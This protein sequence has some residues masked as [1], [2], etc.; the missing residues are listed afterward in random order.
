MT[1]RDARSKCNGEQWEK[2]GSE[3][4]ICVRSYCCYSMAAMMKRMMQPNQMLMRSIPTE[5]NG[6]AS[7]RREEWVSSESGDNGILMQQVMDLV[8]RNIDHE[9]PQSPASG[10]NHKPLTLSSFLVTVMNQQGLVGTIFGLQTKEGYK[11][12]EE[13]RGNLLGMRTKE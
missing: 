7:E 11:G 13:G 5:S 12:I 3:Y 1:L 6:C 4:L 9:I 8:H 2:S 10:R